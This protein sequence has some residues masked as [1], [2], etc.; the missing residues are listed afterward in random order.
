MT[1]EEISK[2]I[3]RKE[4]LI[5]TRCFCHTCNCYVGVYFQGG[6]MTCGNCGNRNDKYT[7]YGFRIEVKEI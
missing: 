5:K 2:E 3:K 6:I 7:N 4:T 1:D